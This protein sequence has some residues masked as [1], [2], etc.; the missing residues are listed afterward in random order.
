MS[1]SSPKYLSNFFVFLLRQSVVGRTPAPPPP[2][3]PGSLVAEPYS[4]KSLITGQP[5]LRLRTTGNRAAVLSLPPGR[6][7]LRFMMSS[8]L[9]HT[10]HLCS[11]I[12]FVFGD[13]ESVMKELRKES[14]RFVDN[15]TQVI[16]CIGKCINGFSD[17]E[18]FKQGWEELINCHCP[19]RHDKTMSKQYHFQIFNQAL[20][21]TL[22]ESLSEILSHDLAFAWRTFTFD[23]VTKN[24]LG[25]PT[26]SRP[27]IAQNLH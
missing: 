1:S 26:S 12:P 23:A 15:A 25:L 16:N 5:I 27:A 10:V 9:G 14:C 8:P 21:H 18:G 20:Y 13:E 3:N 22:K 7:V 6:H 19:Y 2:V 24:I 11:T 4:W 17:P